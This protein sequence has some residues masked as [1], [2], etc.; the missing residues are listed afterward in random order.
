MQNI[1]LKTYKN[2]IKI[3]FIFTF[4]HFS[5]NE[6]PQRVSGLIYCKTTIGNLIPFSER[7]CSTC[8][9][10]DITV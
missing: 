3:H 5:I 1:A 2:D 4:R 10:E 6:V 8:R 7:V 9:T